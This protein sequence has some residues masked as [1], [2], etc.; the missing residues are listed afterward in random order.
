MVRD[1][2]CLRQ[3]LHFL[4]F[5]FSGTPIVTHLHGGFTESASDGNPEFFFTPGFAIKGPQWEKEVYRYENAH[6]A[7]N[8][9]YHDHVLGMTR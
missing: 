5:L 2:T 4:T 7:A 9:W 8:L 1:E 6:A 3:S